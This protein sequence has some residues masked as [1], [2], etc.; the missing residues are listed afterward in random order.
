MN[1][2]KKRGA[3][4]RPFFNNFC[5]LISLTAKYGCSILITDHSSLTC[6]PVSGG[7]SLWR[8]A[9]GRLL[10]AYCLLLIAYCL[11][12]AACCLLLSHN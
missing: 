2:L 1:Y 4:N 3:V 9:A 10:T 11:L 6:L 8:R 7:Q 12:L 5:P